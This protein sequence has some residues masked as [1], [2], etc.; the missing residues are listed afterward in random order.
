M[1]F[2][3]ISDTIAEETVTSEHKQQITLDQANKRVEMLTTQLTKAQQTVNELKLLGLKT[4]KEID[5]IKAEEI[6]NA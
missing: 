2:K 1:G 6:I 4:K 3:K 5:I